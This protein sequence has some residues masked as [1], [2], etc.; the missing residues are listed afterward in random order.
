M[1]S[2][3]LGSSSALNVFHLAGRGST[4]VAQIAGWVAD[5]LGLPP[6]LIRFGDG[7]RGWPGDVPRFAYDCRKI[8]ALG[9]TPRLDSDAAVRRAIVEVVG[10]TAAEAPA[11]AAART[12]AER[13]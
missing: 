11:G 2:A 5:A 3:W 9:W 13:A 1:W 4:T 6:H 8:E 10:E 7:D 12:G